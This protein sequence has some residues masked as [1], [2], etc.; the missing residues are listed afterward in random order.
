MNR[1]RRPTLGRLLSAGFRLSAALLAFCVCSATYR[2]PMP[3]L[4]PPQWQDG[5][6]AVYDITRSDTV[7]YRSRIVIQFDEEIPRPVDGAASDTAGAVATLVTTNV[8][9]PVEAPSYFFDSVTVVMR[10]ADL[11]PLRSFRTLSTDISDVEVSVRYE[12]D[13]AFVSKQTVDGIQEDVL[14]LP[15][16]SYANDAVQTLLRAVPLVPGTTFRIDLVLSMDLR[17][18]PVT[19]SVLGTKVISTSLGDIMCREVELSS[20]GR[21]ARLWYELAEPHRF[22]GMLDK[23][24]LTRVVISSWQA[25]ADTLQPAAP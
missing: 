3:E 21:V 5:E 11:R 4:V 24:N 7:L 23:S 12:P 20:P 17:A 18:L 2:S 25:S 22:V 10:R 8:V 13:R 15:A 1:G 14:R 6:T 16:R 9:L 19:V